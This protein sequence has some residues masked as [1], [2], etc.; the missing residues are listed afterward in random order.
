MRYVWWVGLG[1]FLGAV[2]RYGLT[3]VAGRIGSGWPYGT[4][5]V[6]A[7]GCLL[8]G[9]LL[10]GI[11]RE[12]VAPRRIAFVGVGLLGALTT[13]S[14]FGVETFELL[15]EVGPAAALG[16]VAL[17]LALGLGAVAGGYWLAGALAE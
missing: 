3:Y 1:G 11:E 15:R 12:A 16:N 17:Q 5:L 7:L 14:T 13:F 2:L 8:A 6:N 4:L 9:W 10:F